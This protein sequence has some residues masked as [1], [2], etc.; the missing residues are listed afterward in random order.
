MRHAPLRVPLRRAAPLAVYGA[1]RH[2]GE[3]QKIERMMESFAKQ[4][5]SHSAGPMVNHETAFVLSYS[6]R[7]C[8]MQHTTLQHRAVFNMQR[9]E[10]NTQR[11]SI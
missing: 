3:A 7:A 6:V 4:L 5:Y 8:S 10:F 11:A 9:A 1:C 2:T